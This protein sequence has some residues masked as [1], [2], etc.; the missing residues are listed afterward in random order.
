MI[1]FLNFWDYKRYLCEFDN[2]HSEGQIYN[3]H[4]SNI[5]C[6][7]FNKEN[8]FFRF[9]I[10]NMIDFA[11]PYPQ[12]STHYLLK[13]SITGD[14][15]AAEEVL[16]TNLAKV[17]FRNFFGSTPLHLA[18]NYQHPRLVKFY[19]SLKANPNIQNFNGETPLHC[20]CLHSTPSVVQ[21]L[22]RR[23]AKMTTE[24]HMG[25]LPIH[26][27]ALKSRDQIIE[28][29]LDNGFLDVNTKDTEGNTPLL[30]LKESS[31]SFGSALKHLLRRG[32]DLNI[33]NNDGKMLT[34]PFNCSV[35]SIIEHLKKMKLLGYRVNKVT[36]NSFPTRENLDKGV[37]DYRNELEKLKNVVVSFSPRKTLY[38]CLFL[39][40]NET[41]IYSK[42]VNF[43]KVCR[44]NGGDFE[45]EFRHYGSILNII[46]E[47]GSRRSL[48]MDSAKNVVE[49]SLM[50]TLPEKVSEDIFKYLSD[51]EL[52]RFCDTMPQSFRHSFL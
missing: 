12:N 17:D 2:I 29:L 5:N 23:S 42:N 11:L 4:C 38:D 46:H 30:S 13:A 33:A 32:A 6:K 1:E 20:A 7:H 8:S 47:R 44:R 24:D 36:W 22:L 37:E 3:K 48:M 41:A 19:L 49:D 43:L 21:L 25:R 28:V 40:R 15:K 16:T 45:K 18:I 35:R 34:I 31:S 27:A 51:K 14:K 52:G 50:M 39:K 9:Q 10:T 26:Y